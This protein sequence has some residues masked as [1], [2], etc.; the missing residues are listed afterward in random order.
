MRMGVGEG[1]EHVYKVIVR[2]NQT[3]GSGIRYQEMQS[4]IDGLSKYEQAVNSVE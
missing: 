1:Q 2:R 4:L 3:G